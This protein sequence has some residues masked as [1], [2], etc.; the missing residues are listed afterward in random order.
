MLFPDARILVFAKPPVPGHSKTRIIPALGAQGAAD[1]HERLVKRTLSTATDARLCAVELWCA[2]DTNHSFFYQCQQ[3]FSVPLQ[4]QQ[5]ADLGERMANALESA[6]E[7]CRYAILIGTDCPATTANDLRT[8]IMA[9]KQGNDCVLRPAQD[10]GYVLVGLSNP[11]HLI[12][13]NI[14]WGSD[15]VMQ[16]T[17]ERLKSIGWHWKELD[18]IWDLDRPE[19]LNKLSQLAIPL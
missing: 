4:T 18:T 3:Q 8:A 6:L 7:H 17:R 1:L 9:L 16:T 15:T 10:G 12:F 11:N 2:G 14:S 19:D 13:Q 5:G